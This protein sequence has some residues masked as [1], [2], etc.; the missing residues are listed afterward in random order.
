MVTIEIDG[1][2][3]Q[4]KA[5][6]N[7]LEACLG[8][9]QDL[10]YFCWHP[11][12]GSVGS[13]RQ[14]AVTVYADA[15]DSRGR[16]LMG[17]MTPVADGMR[18]SIKHQAASE[19]RDKCIEVTM[20][21][22]PHDCPV[23]EEAGECH[24]QDVTH[25][26]N[27]T[28]RR[29]QGAKRTYENQNLG[30]CINHEMNRCITCYRCVRF[31]NDYAGGKD[32][33]A[34]GSRENTYF[35][36]HEDGVLESVFSGNLV[37]VC[38]TGVFTDKTLARSYNRKWDLQSAPSICHGCS[39]G[40]N[41]APGERKGRI[42]RIINRYH[43]EVNGYFICD[44]GRFGYDHINSDARVRACTIN[45]DG[46]TK[47]IDYEQAIQ[48]AC[49]HL[50]AHSTASGIEGGLE[51]GPD[52]GLK[53]H[54]NAC[55]GFGSEKSSVEENFLLMKLV[56]KENFCSGMSAKRQ[57]LLREI[58][59]IYR[60]DASHIVSLKAIEDCDAVI[61]LG[62]D[63]INSAPRMAMSVRQATR[64]KSF[65]MAKA[66][67]IPL[68]QDASVRILAQAA[69]SPLIVASVA[70]TE[71][72]EIASDVLYASP[73]HIARFAQAVAHAIDG[74]CPPV[75][76]AKDQMALVQSAAQALANAKNPL[77]ISGTSLNSLAI[78]QAAALLSGA[79]ANTR[80]A[81]QCAINFVL[82]EVNSMGLALLLDDQTLTIEQALQKPRMSSAIILQNDL[83]HHADA[84]KVDEFLKNI[85]TV[86]ALSQVENRTTAAADMVFPARSFAETEGTVVNNEG[87][88]QRFFEVFS[89]TNP[90]LK[91][92]WRTLCNLARALTAPSA[93]S[94]SSTALTQ[95]A[96]LHTFDDVV[97][98]VAE[99]KAVFRSW[100]E[101]A[102]NALF[103][104]AGMKIPRQPHRYSGRTSL[105]A[106][107]AVSEKKQPLDTD[108]PLSFS[109]EGAPIHQPAST[110]ALIWSP[111]WNSNEAINKF[112]SEIG[113]ALLGGD[114]GIR[115][116]DGKTAEQGTTHGADTATHQ[117][118][119]APV[120]I[121]AGQALLAVSQSRLFDGCELSM[122]SSALALRA[123][124]RVAM[125][126]SSTAARHNVADGEHIDI[127]VGNHSVRLPIRIQPNMPAGIVTVPDDIHT[128]VDLPASLLP[129]ACT[130][131]TH[132]EGSR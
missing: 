1:T 124:P 122:L 14:C 116:L 3:F 102:P 75:E 46:H 78:V 111:G 63:L 83:F 126:D 23:C 51:S 74:S 101:V 6:S 40:C 92:N 132:I 4:V 109:M 97:A 113:G 54:L 18:V 118:T 89:S 27:H 29:Y 8:A 38:P 96:A 123:N 47:A 68:W 28:Q 103:R 62:E 45:T 53:S 65:D 128:R 37:E 127:V 108:S 16:L 50:S 99:H 21:N 87:R 25:M 107:V 130:L 125:L 11:A 121:D 31:Y 26:S 66:T 57:A 44:K 30:P 80:A 34:L 79:I 120:G 19:F 35:G 93:A 104:I 60:R 58:L 56:G 105:Y 72:D 106:D 71:L 69:R 42:K 39:L 117:N 24:L 20:A 86:I 43:G 112:Q 94:Q 114:P 22:H 70:G 77:V 67:R 115:L 33:A 110:N 90:A 82:P 76:L 119:L 73:D 41:I 131:G 15:N 48:T 32:L 52:S 49:T 98:L 88:A 85:P 84:Q 7:V 13:C 10:P 64:N 59:A 2:K 9:G 129:A 61:V 36:R 12:M 100:P 91:D 95:L 81:Q 55:L 5:G 17:C